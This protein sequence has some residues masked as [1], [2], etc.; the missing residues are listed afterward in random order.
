EVAHHRAGLL[1]EPGLIETTDLIPVEHRRR[2]DDLT[3]RDHTRPADAGHADHQLVTRN[4][5]L[6]LRN[7]AGRSRRPPCRLALLGG[8]DRGE[9]GAVAVDARVVEVA[10]RLIDTCLA[11]ELGLDGLHREAV[12]LL[13]A[14]TAAFADTFVDQHPEL[15]CAHAIALAQAT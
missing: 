7:V 1:G 3:H 12:A 15:G 9:T 13:T 6:W 4:D 11:A 2:A 8:D 14:V 5:Q 10:G